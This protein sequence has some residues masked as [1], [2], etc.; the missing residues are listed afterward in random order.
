[1]RQFATGADC[2]ARLRELVLRDG[3]GA[4]NA[5]YTLSNG[6]IGVVRAARHAGL[7]VVHEQI[8]NP[9]VGRILR[10]ERELYPGIEQQDSLD[11]VID[12][13]QRDIA[14]WREAHVLLAPSEFVRAGMVRM[15]ADPGKI[16]VV[17]YGLSD[18]WLSMVQ[19]PV[20]GRVLFVGSVGLRK[21]NHY[22]AQAKRILDSR[23]VKTEVRVVG[24]M[25]S[26]VTRHP[27]FQGPFY[28]GQVPR[29]CVA[30]EFRHADIFVLPTLSDSFALV[31]LEAMSC[32]VPVITTPN[33]GS[34]VRDGIDGFIVPIRAPEAIADRIEMV[35]ENRELRERMSR[36]AKDRAREFTWARYGERLLGAISTWG[37]DCMDSPHVLHRHL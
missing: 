25:N 11:S 1:M 30:D 24:P 28:L 33:C 29:P 17:E 37:E 4:A 23:G 27:E 22:L 14:Q 9:D 7:F 18:E 15:G 31:H 13:E 19:E 34:V 3:F 5:L 21:G 35:I 8:L 26:V 16:A 10:E 32:G 12:D 2:E 36:N 20:P 6:D